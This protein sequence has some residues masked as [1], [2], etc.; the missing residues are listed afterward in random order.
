ML[1]RNF[2]RAAIGGLSLPLFK[3][4][5]DPY[6]DL[7]RMS[8]NNIDSKTKREILLNGYSDRI[9]GINSNIVMYDEYQDLDP[10]LMEGY[11][12]CQ[13]SQQKNPNILRGTPHQNTYLLH[14][15]S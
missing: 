2:L 10:D 1:R 15:I 9:R 7:R 8:S 14:N 13:Q 11:F 6:V 5:V 3:S 4:Y 12:K